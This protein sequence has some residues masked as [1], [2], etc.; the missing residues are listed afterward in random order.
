MPYIYHHLLASVWLEMG[1]DHP[2]TSRRCL[3]LGRVRGERQL[4]SGTASAP[5][6]S[7]NPASA[8]LQNV[9]HFKKRNVAFVVAPNLIAIQHNDSGDILHRNTNLYYFRSSVI[10]SKIDSLLHIFRQDLG[11]CMPHS[12]NILQCHI[13]FCKHIILAEQI[14]RDCIRFCLSF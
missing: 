11:K 9:H 6:S 4:H 8:F 1:Q 10:W 14:K 13:M 7:Q 3:G 2:H 5:A 12:Y